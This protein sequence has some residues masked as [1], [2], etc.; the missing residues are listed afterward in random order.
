MKTG[1]SILFLTITLIFT[2]CSTTK[3]VADNALYGTLWE[4]EYL[5]GPRIAFQGLYPD[6]QPKIT[7]MEDTGRVQGTNSC[8][9]YSA[10]FAVKDNEISFGEPGPTTLMFCGQGEKFFL[11][12]IQKIDAY[13]IDED[14]KL[15][16]L[17]GGA[18][19]MRF[20]AIKTEGQSN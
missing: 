4:L 20:K 1:I 13:K 16:L 12:T 8:N 15:A 14:G 17:M 6:R 2:S 18:A 7:F 11:N 9:G 10:P 19:M 5:S 3:K